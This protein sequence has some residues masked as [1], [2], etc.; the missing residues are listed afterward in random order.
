MP[1]SWHPVPAFCDYDLPQA[2]PF[3]F[4]A[5]KIRIRRGTSLPLRPLQE[6]LFF[7]AAT[8]IRIG[9]EALLR[10]G[11]APLRRLLHRIM[12]SPWR[13]VPACVRNDIPQAG[14]SPAQQRWRCIDSQ[15]WAR[16]QESMHAGF[17]TTICRRNHSLLP[18][19]KLVSDADHI[20]ATTV[21][22]ETI[23]CCDNEN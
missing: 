11:Q 12:P 9:R 6:K 21:A 8:K 10:Q 5:T 18:Q 3:P 4:A 1:P 23:L 13:P 22:G 14:H 15:V 17:A 7:L 19:R 16:N 2:K 20:V